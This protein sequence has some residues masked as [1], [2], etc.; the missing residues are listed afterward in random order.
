MMKFRLYMIIMVI[1]VLQINMTPK[2]K[3]LPIGFVFIDISSIYRDGGQLALLNKDGNDTI[4]HIKDTKISIDG[5][6]YDIIKDE[7]LYRK[8]IDVEV[9]FPEYGLFILRSY[10]E[11]D[12]YYSVKI[13]KVEGLIK[14]DLGQTIF[15]DI[16]NYVLETFP[17]PTKSNSLRQSPDDDSEIIPNY[18]D[19]TYLPVEIKGNWVKVRDNKDCY[20]GAS[21]SKTNIEGWIKWKKDDCF[22]LKVGHIC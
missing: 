3:D 16:E 19:Y 1:S 11:L 20:M 15:K 13:N 6:Q 2:E 4:F 7:S 21:P 17:M 14:A 9:F 8:K 18:L 10:E 5:S 22:I 12:G